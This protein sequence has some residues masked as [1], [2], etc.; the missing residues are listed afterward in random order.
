MLTEKQIPVFHRDLDNVT[1]EINF[2]I[3]Y[4]HK[5]IVYIHFE[6]YICKFVNKSYMAS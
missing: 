4:N 2:V 1:K 3:Y 6:L 5:Y